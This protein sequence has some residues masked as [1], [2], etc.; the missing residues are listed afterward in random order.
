M[1]IKAFSVSSGNPLRIGRRSARQLNT[2]TCCSRFSDMAKG[3][4]YATVKYL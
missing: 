2:S 1:N 3:I 4:S